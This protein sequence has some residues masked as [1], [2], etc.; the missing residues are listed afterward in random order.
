MM[1]DLLI[2][3]V[4]GFTHGNASSGI[5]KNANTGMKKEKEK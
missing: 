4:V 1:D 2:R 3:R 5:F